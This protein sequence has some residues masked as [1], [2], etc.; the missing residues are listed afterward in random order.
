LHLTGDDDEGPDKAEDIISQA[1]PP[2]S[3]ESLRKTRTKL[4][5]FNVQ[6]PAQSTQTKPDS[7]DLE[8]GNIALASLKTLSPSNQPSTC[9]KLDD[10]PDLAVVENPFS[11]SG[12]SSQSTAAY[13]RDPEVP[14]Q[15]LPTNISSTHS[16]SSTG[17]FCSQSKKVLTSAPGEPVLD[18]TLHVTIVRPPAHDPLPNPSEFVL[19]EMDEQSTSPLLDEE[20]LPDP[21]HFE[22]TE[23][24]PLGE[25]NSKSSLAGH[26]P[27][28]E[29]L[30][31]FTSD[32]ALDDT[33]VE[34]TTPRPVDELSQLLWVKT[35]SD[36]PAEDALQSRM[37]ETLNELP[38]HQDDSN[39]P[40]HADV[41][42]SLPAE[43][44]P[45]KPLV[46][47]VDESAKS[48][49]DGPLSKRSKKRAKELERLERKRRNDEQQK[50]IA[51]EK[52]RLKEEQKR[53]KEE[54]QKKLD[55]EQKLQKR[56]EQEDQ[57]GLQHVAE[58]PQQKG[59]PITPPQAPL[60]DAD[61]EAAKILLALRSTTA[62]PSEVV[63]IG[64]PSEEEP[65]V[66]EPSAADKGLN[67][68]P[69]S[70]GQQEVFVAPP[71]HEPQESPSAPE[72]CPISI[73]QTLVSIA[74]NDAARVLASLPPAA[75]GL[76]SLSAVAAAERLLV[77]TSPGMAKS[78]KERERVR[79]PAD[80]HRVTSLI[81]RESPSLLVIDHLPILDCI[82]D[83]VASIYDVV[84]AGLSLTTSQDASFAS[85]ID[86][87]WDGI[88]SSSMMDELNR[89]QM[90]K[91][92]RNGI[93]CL[94]V[95]PA[96]PFPTDY[97]AADQNENAEVETQTQES[98]KARNRKAERERQ[99]EKKRLKEEEKRLEKEE[100]GKK[101]C[102][103][104][105]FIN[106]DDRA[107]QAVQVKGS[108]AFSNGAQK[109]FDGMDDARA[110]LGH[111]LKAVTDKLDQKY[112]RNSS[113]LV[114]LAAAMNAVDKLYKQHVG[115]GPAGGG[116]Q[117]DDD[118]HYS[119][120]GV[121]VRLEAKVNAIFD[122]HEKRYR[123]LTYKRPEFAAAMKQL[124]MVCHEHG[125]D[126]TYRARR[127]MWDKHDRLVH[128]VIAEAS[129]HA[130]TVKEG[131]TKAEHND[132]QDLLEQLQV[133][134]SVN[135]EAKTLEARL[136]L[137]ANQCHPLLL[138][139]EARLAE[140]Q[141]NVDDE[142]DALSKQDDGNEE[143]LHEVSK[144]IDK[145][146]QEGKDESN[147][148]SKDG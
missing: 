112:N 114:R 59:K 132:A 89:N 71:I 74:P 55:G 77:L 91:C 27:T 85:R 50:I 144:R 60:N 137:L 123:G 52:Q 35:V 12:S 129:E 87:F 3:D 117:I 107:A 61:V 32:D 18:R 54:A 118:V 13:P 24:P 68:V 120:G 2:S 93:T 122:V 143:A 88:P 131:T 141:K 17:E 90:T 106:A 65:P 102:Y 80:Q 31:H 95:W 64:P 70:P 109:V 116:T 92:L 5:L 139:K 43:N 49:N 26:V 124:D 58:S 127:A 113:A 115:P 79:S 16:L 72:E 105:S 29:D 63:D 39:S 41:A 136:E 96:G 86:K 8:E 38:L 19:T 119:I 145:L 15:S 73:S 83:D 81:R 142:S 40:I 103:L 57:K 36:S 7:M 130:A 69:G 97:F 84:S 44:A 33:L 82:P 23:S 101:A 98:R 78:L 20:N 34:D 148:G 100:Q 47:D 140:A 42:S 45:T 37:N 138:K 30:N 11:G 22:I 6:H 104:L 121:Y 133:S 125:L 94:R 126:E 51:E 56:L 1:S 53:L 9:P 4:N 21:S 128:F 76:A 67:H 111:K 108:S 134:D 28:S 99:K 14:P 25:D 147:D 110:H 48:I 135:V 75:R 62:A 46:T 10:I 66:E 146:K